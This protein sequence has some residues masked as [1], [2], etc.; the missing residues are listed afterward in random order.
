MLFILS[1]KIYVSDLTARNKP[2]TDFFLHKVI[3][4]PIQI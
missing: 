4:L 1:I 3:V 2:L